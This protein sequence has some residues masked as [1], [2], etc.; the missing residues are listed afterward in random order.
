MCDADCE[1]KAFSKVMRL[2]CKPD[3]PNSPWIGLRPVKNKNLP[4]YNRAFQILRSEGLLPDEPEKLLPPFQSTI[5]CLMA[6]S[7]DKD[8][9]PLEPSSNQEI[10][11]FS[12][13]S[14]AEQVLNWHSRNARVQNRVLHSIDKIIN[15]ISHHVSQ[16]D[17]HLQ[18]PDTS[19]H[20]MYTDLQSR[21]ARLDADLHQYINQGYFGPDF[22][23]KERE[24]RQLKDQ[25]DQISRDHFTS[26]PYVSR[27]HPHPY[28]PSLI[29]RIQ[30]LPHIPKPPDHSQ[31]F[32]STGDLFRKYPHLSPPRQLDK[33]LSGR[34][35]RPSKKSSPQKKK[36]S[37]HHK[38]TIYVSH[39][40][41]SFFEETPT[42]TFTTPSET[43]YESYSSWETY[44]PALS[45]K[46]YHISN[47]SDS[48]ALLDLSQIFIAFRTDP[49]PST[50]TIETS[51]NET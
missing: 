39:Q 25:L 23:S 16:H 34:T 12:R 20:I 6:C 27:P 40:F 29:F 18:H 49:Q 13:L 42:E 41:A 9:P 38:H 48:Y 3:D 4:I 36:A 22:D 21:V 50:Q 10:N 32:K 24:I 26:T 17:L 28:T 37:D 14:Q 51:S 11:L 15:Q 44:S 19:L 33:P 31:F 5:P 2:S 35:T 1:C 46:S 45:E 7:Y 47:L 30:S 43:S 8:F